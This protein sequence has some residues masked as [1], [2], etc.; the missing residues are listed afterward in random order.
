M[1]LCLDVPTSRYVDIYEAST[2]LTIHKALGYKSMIDH[3]IMV[4]EL[5]L[6]L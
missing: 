6:C 4:L 1:I 3:S 2:I 5:K